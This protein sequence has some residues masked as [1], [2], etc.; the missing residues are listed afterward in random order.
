V[1]P[2]VLWSLVAAL[3][4][5]FTQTLNRKSNLL[6]GA[7]RT[8]FGLLAAVEIILVIRMFVTGENRLLATAPLSALAAF[9][10]SA[11]IH[12]ILGW[13]FL[14]MSQQQIGVARTG[15][16][17]SATPLVGTLLAAILLDEPLTGF[18][19]IGVLATMG[20]VTLISLSR[21][22][23]SGTR[24][25]IPTFG[26]LVSLCWG[27]SPMFIR[28]GLEG[29]DA[30]VLGLTVGLGAALIIHAIMLTATG[31]WSSTRFD[32]RALI[33]MALG[34]LTGAIGIGAQWVAFGLTTI[35]I[36]IT[37]QQL[38]VLVVVALAPIMFRSAMERLNTTLFIG[39]AAVMLG[40]AMVVLSSG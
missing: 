31:S 22:D 27:S 39:I 2:G 1:S 15:A 11:V 37:V 35:A 34:G 40:S 5:G 4:F 17:V 9:T 12:Y 38:A 13:T 30:P 3:G 25:V 28:R 21:G 14:A 18:I 8:A 16:V 33:W 10:A 7:S 29:L 32:R 23:I 20:G 19:I 36:A 6:V 26:L 24:Q